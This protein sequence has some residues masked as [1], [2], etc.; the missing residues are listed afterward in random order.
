MESV[1]V[2]I[3]H[4][5]EDAQTAGVLCAALEGAEIPCWIAP[6]NIR[7]GISWTGAIV[8]AIE[9]CQVMVLVFSSR[10]NLSEQ[11]YREVAQ[12][13]SLRLPLLPVRIEDVLPTDQLAY[14]LNS[15]HWFDATTTPFEQHI[16]M[17]V[18]SV[19]ALVESKI[20]N[21]WKRISMDAKKLRYSY[22]YP[23]EWIANLYSLMDKAT[24][25]K[26]RA[27][28][29]GAQKLDF[30]S[31]VAR[32]AELGYEVQSSAWRDLVMARNTLAHATPQ[33]RRLAPNLGAQVFAHIDELLNL[34]Q[35]LTP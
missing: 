24:Q 4:S 1:D 27:L 28:K 9:E 2:F 33:Q 12:A 6:R 14:F 18:P 20:A 25:L 29:D 13:L 31:R 30:F 17:L 26:L 19:K 3:S 7:P 35:R 23:E 34:L 10:A 32:L 22:E 8:R 11:V 21:E 5:S 16:A 15:V